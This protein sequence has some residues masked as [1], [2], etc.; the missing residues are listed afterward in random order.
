MTKQS[1][2]RCSETCVIFRSLDRGD[3]QGEECFAGA[4]DDRFATF[5]EPEAWE[6]FRDQ[7]LRDTYPE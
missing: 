7:R 6:A 2:L 5:G 1:T 3:R 4:C